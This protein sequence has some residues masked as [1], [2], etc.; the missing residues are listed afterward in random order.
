M[1]LLFV[2]LLLIPLCIFSVNQEEML[3]DFEI[4]KNTYQVRYAPGEWK[5]KYCDWE[6]ERAAEE[7]TLLIMNMAKPNVKEYQYIV[8]MFLQS[9][10]DIHVRPK[11]YSTEGSMLPFSLRS[12]ENRYFVAAVH[13]KQGSIFVGDEVLAFD[14]IPTSQCFDEIV[15]RKNFDPRSPTESALATRYLTFSSAAQGFLV[16][17]GK[18]KVTIKR[19]DEILDLPMEWIYQPERISNGFLTGEKKT[20]NTLFQVNMSDPCYEDILAMQNQL[21]LQKYHQI[22]DKLPTIGNRKSFV[23]QL[24][25][26]LWESDKEAFFH[27]YLFET[28]EGRKVGYVRIPHFLTPL[29]KESE[30][31]AKLITYFEDYSEALIIDVVDNPGGV[32]LFMY[33]LLS[34]LTDKPLALPKFQHTL[35]QRQ[36]S[37]ALEKI[38]ELSHVKS[39]EDAIKALGLTLNG[40]PVNAR[41]A[42]CLLKHCRFIVEEWNGGKQISGFDFPMGMSELPPHRFVRYTKPILVLTNELSISCADFFPAILKDNQRALI[43]GTKTA[44][45]GGAVATYSHPNR[46][47][48]ASYTCTT[49]FAQRA[50]QEPIENLGVQPDIV[51]EVSAEDLSGNYQQYKVAVNEALKSML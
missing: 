22:D 11:F 19:G 6:L 2:I 47:G 30:E 13:N 41:L 45:A 1:R 37:Q 4:I 46:F 24:G 10:R 18:V 9:M 20:E 7:A 32:A 16:K 50:N 40:L 28:E 33:S 27:A 44:G 35:T 8:S 49:S 17:R 23:P 25:D 29:Q 5:K 21:S 48:I 15:K 31:F 39:D 51:Y 34:M 3:R 43:F 12:A 38:D 36:V 14:D 26:L 42:E